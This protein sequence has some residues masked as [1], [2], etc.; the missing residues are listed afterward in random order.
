VWHTIG[1]ATPEIGQFEVV[2]TESKGKGDKRLRVRVLDAGI[3]GPR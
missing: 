2:K 3:S 1:G